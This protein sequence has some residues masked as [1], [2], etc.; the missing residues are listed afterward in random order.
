M[1]DRDSNQITEQT[2]SGKDSLGIIVPGGA[3]PN[4]ILRFNR[5][6]Q[7]PVVAPNAPRVPKPGAHPGKASLAVPPLRVHWRL[8]TAARVERHNL[9]SQLVHLEKTYNRVYLDFVEG[10]E[11]VGGWRQVE[12]FHMHYNETIQ[13]ANAFIN[14]VR[15]DQEKYYRARL[16]SWQISDRGRAYRAWMEAW[17]L[18]IPPPP[19]PT[20]AGGIELNLDASKLLR[21]I[22]TE[23]VELPVASGTTQP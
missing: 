15:D 5:F 17:N 11:G 6:V 2:N 14:A 3:V 18:V 21:G 10:V 13:D 19:L 4:N 23:P 7:D 22:P 16:E 20:R 9:Y 12:R 8:K 1:N